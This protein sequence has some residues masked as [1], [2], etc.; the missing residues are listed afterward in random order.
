LLR[1]IGRGG[2]GVVYEARQIS[3]NRRVA[4][5]V[6]PP[7]LGLT[8]QA[9]QRFEREAHAAA[10]LHHTNIVP[11]YATGKDDGCHY[12]A[13]EL[14]EGQP[15]SDVLRDLS[16]T[17]SNP[18]MDKTVT[19]FGEAEEKGA[20]GKP[21]TSA[22]TSGITSL[23]DTQSG[24]R[25][26]FDAVARLIAE[27]ADALE[28][29]HGRGV[30]HRD[31]KPANLMLSSDGRLCITDFGLARVAQEPGMTVSGSLMGTPAYMSPEQIAV[32]RV[33]LDHRTDVYS[34]GAVLYEMLSHR[35]PFPGE[36]REEVLS[37]ILTKD[38]RQ[39]RRFNPRVPLD[40]E[41]IC[42][43]AMEKDPDKRY[44][45]AGEFANDLRQYLQHGLIAARRAGI[46]K[47]AWKLVRRHP[48]VAT[49]TGAA[50]L[51]TVAA[52]IV[53]GALGG[54]QESEMHRLVSDAR[55]HLVR[56][57]VDEALDKA[58]TILERDP[59]NIEGR[60]IRS[61][62]Q[63]FRWRWWDA[64]ADAREV[65]R[66]D[67]D[68]WEAH[69]LV[70]ANA[71]HG[72]LY[73]IPFEEHLDATE[74]VSPESA[75]ADFLR[76][77]LEVYGRGR[78]RESIP[79]F[80]RALERDPGHVLALEARCRQYRALRDMPAALADAE[81][82][83]IARPR[84]A[85]GYVYKSRALQLMHDAE[86]ALEA[87]NRATEFDKTTGGGYWER[88]QIF[89]VLGDTDGRIEALTRAIEFNPTEARYSSRGWAYLDKDEYDN[90]LE[91]AKRCLEI[92]PDAVGC[93]R[94]IF[95]AHWDAGRR[96]EA[97]AAFDALRA[98]AE[99][100]WVQAEGLARY[101]EVAS[102]YFQM[103][104]E[105]DRALAEAELTIESEPGQVRG[106]L[107][108]A[109]VRR[110]L[111]G[112]AGIT[113]DCDRIAALD[114]A[115]PYEILQRANTMREFCNRPDEAMKNY[116]RAIEMAPHWADI[117]R[118]RGWLNASQNGYEAAIDDYNRAIE[119]APDWHE[120]IFNRGQAYAFLE[121]FEEALSDYKRVFE[122]GAEGSNGRWELA[123]AQLRTGRE[124]EALETMALVVDKWPHWAN[125]WTR[126]AQ[127]FFWLGRTQD[128]VDTV[129]RGIDRLPQE[130]QLY[131]D[132]A[133]F[134]SYLEGSCDAVEADLA[135][136]REFAAPDAAASWNMEALVRVL[137]LH[138]TC[139][140]QSDP[141]EALRLARRAVE[142]DSRSATYLGTLGF[143]L[144]RSGQYAAAR[145]TLLEAA[146]LVTTLDPNDLFFLAMTEW[147]LGN[148]TEARSYY[149]RALARMNATYRSSPGYVL[150]RDEAAEM[151]GIK[152]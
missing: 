122:M 72:D 12:Y 145:E 76:G 136:Q 53:V 24:G 139:P 125:S 88:S 126:R 8:P 149:E 75:D 68:N 21:D 104:G 50:V 6:L 142:F 101:H 147:R 51:L 19:Q 32:G 115:E 90:A 132:R 107:R 85:L 86:G 2:M 144:H 123:V 35:R 96:E 114:F 37:G 95:Q 69:L 45:T 118:Y 82:L 29:A 59:A 146:N 70:A 150:L 84:S 77:C 79:W 99:G 56:G 63:F 83:I 33:K 100:A 130:A 20:E 41:T 93:Y 98:R 40:L 131:V 152:S 81:R 151:L 43:K 137:G 61:R 30:I 42:L 73:S 4:L 133:Y 26:W 110:Q 10:R 17:G 39:P 58:N 28:Y 66:Q 3:L 18:L 78:R 89:R 71:R 36:S 62:L 67:P 105:T 102:R 106:Y 103:T 23:S 111:E 128:A 47:R 92:H 16:G 116:D 34:L 109:E 52:V 9:V 38:P 15:L 49:A 87:A 25:K 65:L 57:E 80:T 44:A 138:H 108:R 129:S 141:A 7:G 5:K 60:L 27:V 127:M 11:V 140:D 31:I 119:V 55:L 120:A 134:E 13:M 148:Q 74:D 54:K 64:L 22:A 113:E 135:R 121:R 112:E 117:H 14:I 46:T 94:L 143:A 1:E 124:R 97:H 48:V 91:D